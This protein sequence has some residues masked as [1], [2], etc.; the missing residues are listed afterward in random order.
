[1]SWVAPLSSTG[2]EIDGAG[3]GESGQLSTAQPEQ[4]L[5]VEQHAT[6]PLSDFGNLSAPPATGVDGLSIPLA[7]DHD[8]LN[9]MHQWNLD[10][11]MD[12]LD[13]DMTQAD[14]DAIL[15][16]TVDMPT[17]SSVTQEP[18]SV[19]P[20]FEGGTKDGNEQATKSCCSG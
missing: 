12:F 11:S 10:P 17:D 8:L 19:V 16:S 15:N 20:D 1:M 2:M 9:D 3:A 14:L 5:S 18:D 4:P 7:A 6:D 13:L